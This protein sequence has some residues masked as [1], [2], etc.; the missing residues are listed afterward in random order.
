LSHTPSHTTNPNFNFSL[1]IIPTIIMAPLTFADTHNMMAFLTKSDASEGFDQ[2]VGFLNAHMIQYA[3]MVNP[4]IYVSCIKQFWTF[5]SIKKSNDFVRLQALIDR[6][7][8]LI[9]KD[10]I[11]QAL[12]LDD[13]DGVDCLPNG[14][15]FAELASM[16]VEDAVEDKDDDH[17]VSAEPTPPSPTPATP[18]PPPQQEP[19]PSPPQTCATLTKQ[20]ANLEQDK[21]AQAIE[22]TKLKQRVKRGCIQIGRKI[23]ELDADKDVTLE[24]V[25]AAVEM[26]ANDTVEAE[27]AEVKEVIEVVTAAK[28]MTE[29][30]AFARELEAE[31]NADINWNDVMEEMEFFKGMT[32][33]D[34]RPIFEKHYNLNQAILERVEEEVIGQKEEGNKR[35]GDSLNQDA[36]KKQK[37]NEE[38]EE[39]KTHLQI[40]A[41]DDDSRWN[42]PAILKL[43]HFIEDFDREDLEMLWKLVQERFQSSEPKNFSDDFLLSTLKIMFEKPNVEAS[44]WRDQKGRYGLAKV[45]RL[46]LFE[47]CRVRILTL[48]TTQMI[49]LVEKKYPLTRF[50]LEQML[51]N[52]RLEVEEKSKMSLELL[53]DTRSAHACNNS[54][55]AYCN[56]YDVYLNDLFVF[57]DICLWIIDSGCSKYMTGNRA[58]LTNFVENFRGTVRFGNNDFVVIAGYGDV[59]IRSMEIK[60]VY[61]VKGLGHNLFSVG[62]FCDKGLE[63]AFRKPTCFIRNENGVDLLTGDRSP[64]LYTIALSEVA[65][66][67]SNCLLAKTSSLQS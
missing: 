16:A 4:T 29:D 8:V 20:V 55:N 31:L 47:S 45:K 50:T 19:I 13:A 36:A 7:M 58:L 23:A 6:K 39:P 51:N 66:N 52:V 35:K 32:Y 10:T 18:P 1:L 5:V 15:I 25:D 48:T 57:D 43:H 2:I 49:P 44:I 22:I 24:D 46:K 37:I 21:I 62:Q 12:R 30:E 59:V 53:R 65:L 27:P 40:V 11:R 17:E 3:L 28:L 42:S 38:K 67:S 61:H 60:K 56:S 41:N 26:E 14:E 63:V 34:I 64:N 54:R 33:N 9:T